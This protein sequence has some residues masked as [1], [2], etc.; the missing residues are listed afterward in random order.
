MSHEQITIIYFFK[1]KPVVMRS[2]A[3]RLKS[4][5]HDKSLNYPAS[6]FANNR[7]EAS[8]FGEMKDSLEASPYV[9]CQ[10]KAFTE[11]LPGDNFFPQ[12][13]NK[14]GLPDDLKN[15]AENL[16]GLDLS[17]VRVHYNSCKPA[18]L[19]ALAY[20]QGT[21]IH[22][23]PGEEKHLPHEMWHTVQQKQGRVKPTFSLH[24][25]VRINDDT[26]LEQEATN[27]GAKAASLHSPSPVQ[28]QRALPSVQCAVVQRQ[29]GE[30]GNEK[31]VIEKSSGN[32]YLSKRNYSGWYD[33][34]SQGKGGYTFY[35]TVAPDDD[36]YDLY[37]G[38]GSNDDPQF[39]ITSDQ[40]KR[41]VM[42]FAPVVNDEED[43][44][45]LHDLSGGGGTTSDF[46]YAQMSTALHRVLNRDDL[47]FDFTDE[48]IKKGSELPLE[49]GP[50]ELDETL[51]HDL[52]LIALHLLKYQEFH[53]PP[54][55]VSENRVAENEWRQEEL[56]LTRAWM[57]LLE[58]S[59]IKLMLP[60]MPV[61]GENH[62]RLRNIYPGPI[63]IG[64][65]PD[66][67]NTLFTYPDNKAIFLL[68]K[69]MEQDAFFRRKKRKI[70]KQ[71]NAEEEE[72][73][74]LEETPDEV[75]AFEALQ[76][77]KR[78]AETES[79]L[80]MITEQDDST[81]RDPK[82]YLR[83][84]MK[85]KRSDSR[86][87]FDLSDSSDVE[88]NE[89]YDS[90]DDLE[91]SDH[92][93]KTF[94]HVLGTLVKW[95]NRKVLEDMRRIQ[96]LDN[97]ISKKKRLRKVSHLIALS[98]AR[99][100]LRKHE[101]MLE[102]FE[103]IHDKLQLKLHDKFNSVRKLSE[104][105]R[106]KREMVEEIEPSDEKQYDIWLRYR[107]ELEIYGHDM[108][109]GEHVKDPEN[110]LSGVAKKTLTNMIK[111]GVDPE[112][113]KKVNHKKRKK[114]SPKEGPIRT[115][116]DWEEKYNGTAEYGRSDGNNCLIYAIA[117]AAGYH[118][119]T[120]TVVNEIRKA[121]VRTDLIG[122]TRRG[123]LPAYPRLVDL[124]MQYILAEAQQRNLQFQPVTIHIET[125]LPGIRPVITGNGQQHVYIL[126]DG[127]H[128]WWLRQ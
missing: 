17:D 81:V 40:A 8:T 77:E 16:S 119:I 108:S 91:T 87:S 30:N 33:L 24:S 112:K 61:T 70:D 21:E 38:D 97:T 89:I 4:N 14:T 37:N 48:S 19:Q 3:T 118:D 13:P 120:H 105:Y 113:T 66:E 2:T 35:N 25:G 31:F 52:Q 109:S 94:L 102:K 111:S 68:N 79:Y 11:A 27:M 44:T 104:S 127:V 64:F 56:E 126:H 58:G 74:F 53:T 84:T 69:R 115:L 82:V 28:F 42:T 46:S 106:S 36:D 5:S 18:Q 15:A 125:L 122:F 62:S 12:L 101:E 103:R 93:R 90:D 100:Q 110:V 29:I 63:D 55:L 32:I 59:G 116:S 51:N 92:K 67:K 39:I 88:E 121:L 47:S 124:I 54:N 117:Y 99:Q 23:S 75:E 50:V 1:R 98:Q 80:K 76:K 78:Q 65:P 10:R 9:I 22:V 128:Y 6:Q 57:Q 45:E 114:K 123:F 83:R 34:Y 7:P 96:L 95:T 43:Y 73:L 60:E 72:H 20:T 107:E 49:D 86:D 71:E 85:L 41:R 26:K